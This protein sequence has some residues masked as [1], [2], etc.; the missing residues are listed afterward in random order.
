MCFIDYTKA[1]DT[2][3]HE[4][5]WRTMV[6]MGFSAHIIQLM[7]AFYDQQ[8]A[9]VRT[10]YGPTDWFRI[11]QGVR[12][13]CILSPNLFNIYPEMIMRKALENFEGSTTVGG[14]KITNL[15]YADD[16]VLIAG[17]MEKLQ[18]LVGRGRTESEKAR[19]F[20]NAKKTKVMEIQRHAERDDDSHIMINNETVENV[21]QFTYLGAVFTNNYDDSV[22]IKRS[23]GIAK[24]A[25]ISLTKIWKNGSITLKTKMRL[26]NTQV[27]SIASYGAECLVLK[28]SDKKRIQSFEM[29]CYRRLL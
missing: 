18:F 8:K 12:Q 19:L 6:H 26:L 7:M 17:S 10:A 4:V 3:V 13:G 16:I 14:C 21:T 22:E 11:E 25:T 28:K 5:L 23:I 27:F 1:F 2:V 29:W 24:N 15:R 20:L 9:S